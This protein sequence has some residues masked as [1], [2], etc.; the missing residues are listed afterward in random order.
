MSTD[1]DRQ[2]AGADYTRLY[3]STDTSQQT[4]QERQSREGERRSRRGGSRIEQE[5]E[6]SNRARHS[7]NTGTELLYIITGDVRAE[8]ASAKPDRVK[9]KSEIK[10]GGSRLATYHE[11][12]SL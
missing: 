6:H 12:K 4:T 3:D 9:M 2:T 8:R 11:Q 10:G 7:Q 1:P 5:A